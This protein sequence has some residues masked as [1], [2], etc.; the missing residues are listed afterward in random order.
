MERS[1]KEKIHRIAYV[2][3]I[4]YIRRRDR[5]NKGS[6][7]KVFELVHRVRIYLFPGRI[8]QG[9][10]SASKIDLYIEVE[11][12]YRGERSDRIVAPAVTVAVDQADGEE[13]RFNGCKK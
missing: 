12:A 2:M 9:E 8:F 6:G 4:V 5:M 13:D 11:A 1:A 7:G 10:S 3:V